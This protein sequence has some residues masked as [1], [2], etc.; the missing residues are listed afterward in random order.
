[1]IGVNVVIVRLGYVGM[2]VLIE[3]A[4]P[5]RMMTK[6]NFLKIADREAAIHKLERLA[7]EN[8]HNTLRILRHNHAYDIQMF[9]FSSKLIPL[10]GIDFL[11]AWDPFLALKES[12]AKIGNYV[13][14]NEM[15]VSFH[16]DHFTVLSTP[17][18]EVLNNSLNDLIRHDQMLQAMELDNLSKCNIHIGG[19]YGDKEAG[20]FCSGDLYPR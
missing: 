19:A 17:R 7:L 15:R 12:F 2:S 9:R 13:R 1:M 18:S 10:F 11:E 5:S 14:K 8:L 20:Y 16:P 3:N 6:T 4:S